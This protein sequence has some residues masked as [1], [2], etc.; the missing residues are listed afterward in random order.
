MFCQCGRYDRVW[1]T[2]LM[3]LASPKTHLFLADQGIRKWEESGRA[4]RQGICR[5]D[6]GQGRAE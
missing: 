6:Y 3:H 4:Q 2:L 5:R 1:K